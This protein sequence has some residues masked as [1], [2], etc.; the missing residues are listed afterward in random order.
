MA[1]KLVA[2]PSDAGVVQRYRD[3]GDGSWALSSVAAAAAAGAAGY[4]VG[5]TPVHAASGNVAA[6]VASAALAAAAGKTTY[7]TGFEITGGGA[8]LGS[9]VSATLAGILGGTAT[10][11]VPV[12]AGVLLGNAPISFSFIPPIP[13]S[14]LN[15]AIT[16][17]VP[18]L[19]V[20]NTNSA[21][22]IHGFQI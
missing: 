8:T 12:L 19:G 7:C 9:L 14:A 11:A 15:T 3:M 22:A 5:A 2:H 17:S 20:G 1:D 16:L 21:V 4:P 18:S 6:G 10:Y 13:A